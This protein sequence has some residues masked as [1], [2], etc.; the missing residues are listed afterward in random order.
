MAKSSLKGSGFEREF[1]KQLSLWWT[2]GERDDVFWRSQNSGG[3]AT[4]R[5]SAGR[6]TFMQAGDIAAID[7]DGLPLLKAITF[8][9]KRGYSNTTVA[10]VFD[11]RTTQKDTHWEKFI[12]Q[13]IN[14]HRLNKS[15][16]WM[17]VTK[18]DRRY[19]LVWYP[20][21][22][23]Q[24]L[25]RLGCPRGQIQYQYRTGLICGTTLKEFFSNVS[26]EDILDLLEI[27]RRK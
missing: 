6:S 20:G 3:R 27:Q 5:K 14:S 7:P 21:R 19:P 2:H 15:Y 26:R 8:E 1:S 13:A 25:F 23:D 10:E 9:L 4:I 22:L 24:S 12:I 11:K 17:L 18:R 16:A